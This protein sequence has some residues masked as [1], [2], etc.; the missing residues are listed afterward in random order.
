MSAHMPSTPVGSR[1]RKVSDP[2]TETTQ[3]E[4]EKHDWCA[5][6]KAPTRPSAIPTP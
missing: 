1:P 4:P 6:A 5:A 2:P 3:G